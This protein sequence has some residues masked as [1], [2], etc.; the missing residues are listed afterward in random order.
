[1]GISAGSGKA[2]NQMLIQPFIN[3]N[4]PDGHGWYVSTSPIIT[5]NWNSSGEKWVVPVGFAVGRLFKVGKLP[6]NVQLGFYDNVITPKYGARWQS[7][8]KCS[9]CFDLVPLSEVISLPSNQVEGSGATLGS[10]SQR[11]AFPESWRG[12]PIQRH[13]SDPPPDTAKQGPPGVDLDSFSGP[14]HVEWEKEAA[15]TPLHLGSCRSSST[16]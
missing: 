11:A 7:A 6:I 10:A 1:M 4:V 8:F 14:V 5:A 2:V 3:Y 15:M 12:R 9:S 16:F 13:S